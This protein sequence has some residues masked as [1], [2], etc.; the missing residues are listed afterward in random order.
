MS[1]LKELQRQLTCV[2][3][4]WLPVGSRSAA[5]LI[6]EIVTGEE[7]DT[8]PNGGYIS[9]FELY[10]RAMQ[11]AGANTSVILKLIEQLRQG[12][13]IQSL[14]R[15]LPSGVKDFL[16]FTFD[17]IEASRLHCTAA[18]FTF[19]REDLIPDM[20]L[21]L[22]RDLSKEFPGQ[23]DVF[24]Y[25]LERHI[26]VDGDH[27]GHLAI[28]MLCDICGNDALKWKEAEQA[29]V[30]SLMYRKKLWDAALASVKQLQQLSV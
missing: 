17:T 11:E 24:R 1:L 29:A 3:V 6:N 5:F 30:T 19:G 8:D 20:F 27:H 18:V 23:T 15:E 25:Y 26:E 16:A 13:H 2:N 9:H 7:S 12:K 28:E 21:S 4:P 22:V 14:I 10:L